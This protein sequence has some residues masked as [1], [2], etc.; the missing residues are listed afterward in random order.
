[1][2]DMPPE[3][4]PDTTT[5]SG[6]IGARIRK[7]RKDRDWSVEQLRDALAAKHV[8][9]AISTIYGIENGSREI[10]VDHMPGFAAAFGFKTVGEFLPAK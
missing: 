5:Y 9:I 3:K 8:T 2:G 4:K 7:L 10:D 1:M 6:R